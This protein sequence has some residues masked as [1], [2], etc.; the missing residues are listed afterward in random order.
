[1]ILTVL[2]ALA[3]TMCLTMMVMVQVNQLAKDLP[4]Y[5]VT[6]SEKIHDLRDIVGPSGLLKAPFSF[7]KNLGKELETPDALQPAASASPLSR[8][9][10]AKPIPVEVHQPAPGAP[11]TLFALVQPL[12]SPLTMTLVVLIFV[13]FFLF[14]RE[15]LRDR[16]IRVS[17][18]R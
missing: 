5:Q 14:Q 3:L 7:L 16:F 18:V 4:G 9:E 13:M 6:L 15:D 10:S 2:G 1:V 11:E 12:L 8:S 17:V